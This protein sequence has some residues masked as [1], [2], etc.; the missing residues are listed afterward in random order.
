[1]TAI[2]ALVAILTIGGILAFVLLR[3]KNKGGKT[4]PDTDFIL[5]DDDDEDETDTADPQA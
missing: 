4:T 1:M 5:D 3:N 2:L